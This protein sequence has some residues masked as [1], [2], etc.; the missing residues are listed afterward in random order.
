MG[1]PDRR[2]ASSGTLPLCACPNPAV[3]IPPTRQR[4]AGVAAP[5]DRRGPRKAIRR[6]YRR[7]RSATGLSLRWGCRA[8]AVLRP[9]S[10]GAGGG[11]VCPWRGG[12]VPGPRPGTNAGNR[13]RR[14]VR[15]LADPRESISSAGTPGPAVPRLGGSERSCRVASGRPKA[16]R[17]GF[18]PIRL[19]QGHRQLQ[20][21]QR[22]GTG[23]RRAGSRTGSGEV[24]PGCV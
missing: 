9:N 15:S 6:I 16:I 19:S 4:R 18:A 12:A 20:C 3:P 23:R 24:G 5:S 8:G 1:G 2:F 22:G 14:K 17:S 21:G 13:S 7:D 11:G 10:G